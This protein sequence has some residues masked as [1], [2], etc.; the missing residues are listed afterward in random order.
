MFNQIKTLNQIQKKPE[1][2]RWPPH[3][4]ALWANHNYVS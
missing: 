3:N 4:L 1:I 2:E